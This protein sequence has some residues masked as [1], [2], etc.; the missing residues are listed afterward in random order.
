V[1]HSKLG[2]AWSG[3]G[4]WQVLPRRN[5]DG[6]FTSESSR[7]SDKV[8]LTLSANSRPEQMQQTEQAYSLIS[9][10]RI[11]SDSGTSSPRAF[12][13]QYRDY[14]HLPKFVRHRSGIALMSPPADEAKPAAQSPQA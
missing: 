9:S 1:Q 7:N 8:A 13:L 10:A 12:T 5:I 11:I 14:P 3:W 4:Q 6:R 2:P